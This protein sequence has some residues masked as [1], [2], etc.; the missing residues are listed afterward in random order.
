GDVAPLVNGVPSPDG[1]F[2]LGDL[3]IITRKA[4]GSAE[5]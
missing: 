5:Y 4:I 2:N 3:L 1:V